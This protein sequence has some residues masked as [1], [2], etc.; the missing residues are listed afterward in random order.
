MVNRR[1]LKLFGGL[2]IAMN[3]I[4]IFGVVS[5]VSAAE[6]EGTGTFQQT[7]EAALQ[8]GREGVVVRS[9]TYVNKADVSE[10]LEQTCLTVDTPEIFL[11][12]QCYATYRIVTYGTGGYGL[13]AE[14]ARYDKKNDLDADAIVDELGLGGCSDMEIAIR[15]HEWLADELTYGPSQESLVQCLDAGYG[16]CDDYSMI[17]ATVMNAAG[18]ETRCMDG[19]PSG[20]TSGHMW[21]MVQMDGSWYLCDV[22]N[23][24][25]EGSYDYFMK[26]LD[27]AVVRSY[28]GTYLDGYR[29]CN[30][31]DE[32]LS[33]RLAK[34]DYFKKQEVIDSRTI[35]L[36]ATLGITKRAGETAAVE[37]VASEG[38]SVKRVSTASH[39]IR[40]KGAVHTVY[41]TYAKNKKEYRYL[42]Q[43]R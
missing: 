12:N 3:L 24:D 37:V 2:T 23:D 38:G 34:S 13:T 8:S 15:V 25:L 27:S 29:L 42:I 41:G 14:I 16:K 32:F 43:C 4:N 21:N 10:L 36:A 33:Y 6:I 20:S 39:K 28:L 9:H 35:N 22:T 17:Y 30:G 18:V 1:V 7:V 11:K 19:V 31:V 26:A 5:P 40:L